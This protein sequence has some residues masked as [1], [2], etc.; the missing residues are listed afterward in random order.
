M[1]ALY[2]IAAATAAMLVGTAPAEAKK[3]DVIVR[4][5]AILV[6][7]TERSGG[8]VPAFPTGKVSVDN[9]VT[10][11]LDVTY[12]AANHIGF[13]LIAATTRH[14][15]GGQGALA[16]LGD[17]AK[18]SVLPPTLTAQY[19]FL[20]DAKIRPYVGA[21]INYTIFYSSRATSAL[22]QAIGATHVGLSDSV[23]FAGQA[24]F[25]VDLTR[26]VF[27][28]VDLKY[29]DIRTNAYLRTGGA[30]NTVHVKLNPLVAGIGIG[31]RF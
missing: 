3:G 18:T 30:I 27:L 2:L 15:I 9:V 22:N 10:P 11:E 25:D 14:N 4:V 20:P 29:L 12:M 24:G 16:S 26:R 8:V 1:K 31:T 17:I 7:P 6:A 13:E 21:G 5:R 23:G 28:N 19:H